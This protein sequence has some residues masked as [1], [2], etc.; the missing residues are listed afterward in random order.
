MNVT[1]EV[2][3]FVILMYNNPF[4]IGLILY[5]ILYIGTYEVKNHQR[6]I[7]IKN[8]RKWL[9]NGIGKSGKIL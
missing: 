5:E 4:E 8:D 3:G 9:L 2:L 6:N 1:L 7:L